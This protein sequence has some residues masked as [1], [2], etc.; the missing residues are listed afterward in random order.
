[1]AATFTFATVDDYLAA[2]AGTAPKSWTGFSQTIG[3]PTFDMSN[4][5]LSWFVQDDW[6]VTPDFK[7]LYGVRYDLYMYPDGIANAP[8]AYSQSFNR[9]ANNFAPRAGM[10]WTLGADKRTV[11]R[12]ST[13]LMYDQPLLAI[14]EQ[15]Y[16]NDGNPQRVTV[17]LTPGSPGAPDFP[18]TL[19]DLPNGYSIALSNRTIF[20]PAPDFVT[21][22]T[23]QNSVQIERAFLDKYTASIG[24]IYNRGYDLPVINDINLINPTG[25]LADGRGIYSS[26]VNANT[27][28]D[29]RFNRINVV[30]SV[31]DS[32]YKALTLG[33]GQQWS[34]GIQYDLNYTFGKGIDN[35]VMTSTLSVQGDDGRSDPQDLERDRGPNALD[36]R[37][38]FNGSIVANPHVNRTGVLGAVLNN[39][40]VGVVLQFNSGL[41][42]NVRSN[43]NLNNDGTGS[44]RPL[45]VG[46]NS[47]Y[48]PARWNVD[49]RYSR[50]VPLRGSQRLEVLAEFKNLFNI[51]QTSAVNRV[52]TVDT[53]G[54]PLVAIPAD[55]SGFTPTSG[56]E[57]RKFQ[58]GFKYYF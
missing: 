19:S 30:E 6:K 5:L 57:Q 44:D 25:F 55:G 10:A 1:L 2:R 36:T 42:F 58:L 4:T 50:F 47:V 26:A 24:V 27:R 38:S 15:S 14:I 31:G 40:Q 34:G 32:T 18:S 7:L 56:Y 21:G 23:W 41:P 33:F 45:F 52:I 49:M 48:L 37:H 9:D 39:N 3:E 51:E 22:R 28:M 20:A 11:L 13:G 16:A 54:N 29:P 46:R 12:A 17:S 53:A 35:A 43:R 8:F